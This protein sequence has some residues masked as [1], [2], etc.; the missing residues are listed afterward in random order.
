MAVSNL[1]NT[2]WTINN[3]AGNNGSSVYFYNITFAF[4][5]DNYNYISFEFDSG[6]MDHPCLSDTSGDID[7]A[8]N[9]V[10]A[11]GLTI[12]ITGGTDVTN[13]SLISWLEANA[14]QQVVSTGKTQLGTRTI[15]KKMFGTREITKEVVNG[16]VVYEK[17]AP[18]PSGYTATIVNTLDDIQRGAGYLYFK[19]NTPPTS[20]DDYDYSIRGGV[21]TTGLYSRGNVYV[22]NMGYSDGATGSF[23][24]SDV[25]KLYIWTNYATADYPIITSTSPSIISANTNVNVLYGSAIELTLNADTTIN[26]KLRFDAD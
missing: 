17:Q 7:G 3:N 22:K 23:T 16:V 8:N 25:S 15:T 6:I 21:A 14:T 11:R 26:T 4:P 19:A 18:T 24:M 12:T 9:Y 10:D 2:T 13:A 1:T 5:Y 20:N